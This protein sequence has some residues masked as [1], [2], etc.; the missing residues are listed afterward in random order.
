M[1]APPTCRSKARD[2]MAMRDMA[3]AVLV[4]VQL[5]LDDP[6]EMVGGTNTSTHYSLPG[7]ARVTF[8]ALPSSF[9]GRFRLLHKLTITVEGKAEYTDPEG[10]Y[11][12]LRVYRD[13][14]TLLSS[15]YTIAPYCP[16]F[17]SITVDLPFDLRVP[18]WLP[19]SHLSRHSSTSY[20]LVAQATV[21]WANE[22]QY[23]FSGFG[24]T[25][26]VVNGQFALA[27]M[28]RSAYTP[29]EVRRHRIP[30]PIP[31]EGATRRQYPFR[32]KTLPVDL[33]IRHAEYADL[34]DPKG[35]KIEMQLRTSSVEPAFETA[36]S[37]SPGIAYVAHI[38]MEI[39]EREDVRSTP[40]SQFLASFPLPPQDGLLLGPTSAPSTPAN[41]EPVRRRLARA[42]FLLPSG[43][44]QSHT[45]WDPRPVGPSTKR[46]KGALTFNDI[47]RIP[48]PDA[49]GPFVRVTH[50][51]K[52]HV[53]FEREG[54]Y[55]TETFK[56][57]V[58]LVTHPRPR[59]SVPPPYVT[60]FHENGDL[61]DCDPLPLYT[62]EDVDMVDALTPDSSPP[63]EA[64]S[65]SSPSPHSTQLPEAEAE[66]RSAADGLS[67]ANRKLFEQWAREVSASLESD[68]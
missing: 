21:G 12:P 17:G 16:S 66:H 34:G 4:E 23:L 7:R 47:G 55:F 26:L 52:T 31:V 39:E 60:V 62:P 40:A 59:G 3:L 53:T 29:L 18:G 37:D 38:A 35:I 25:P 49:T 65:S 6:L 22:T 44:P 57:P 48:I 61:R 42:C 32:C 56:T 30:G 45:F 15:P 54:E 41:L 19:P 36:Q 58:R 20:G 9:G 27:R 43:M 14:Q 46:I 33:T 5:A 50:F 68:S 63:V 2:R 10:R 1:S 11:T 28:S 67:P 51:L 24:A 64:A 13:T 8:P